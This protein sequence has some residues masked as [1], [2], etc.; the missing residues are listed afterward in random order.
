MI[1]LGWLISL[2]TILAVIFGFYPMNQLDAIVSDLQNSFYESFSRVS[3]AIAVGW[4]IFACVQGYGGPINWFLSLPQ[5]QP[6]CRLSYCVYLLHTLIQV[7]QTATIRSAIFFSDFN[8]VSIYE[9]F[10]LSLVPNFFFFS[11]KIH[12]FWGDFGLT[13]CI[14]VLWTLAFESPIITLEKLLLGGG[15]RKTIPALKP[16]NTKRQL[17]Q[18]KNN[19]E[20]ETA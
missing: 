7:K 3:W 19:N 5:W 9:E 11:G 16:D 17:D 2:G 15:W 14:S 20:K 4:I 13:L 6:L 8:A 1:A 12:A 18:P 10:L